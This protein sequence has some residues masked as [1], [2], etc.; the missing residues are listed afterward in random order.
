[1]T[2]LAAMLKPIDHGWAV[3]L[4]DG[5]ELARFKGPGALRRATKYV[6]H[7]GST[8]WRGEPRHRA[9]SARRRRWI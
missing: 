1:M 9:G 5:R 4:T 8:K 3:T 6:T 7:D 2:A